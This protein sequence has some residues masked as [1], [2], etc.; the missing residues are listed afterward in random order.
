[1][2]NKFKR[3]ISDTLRSMN[4]DMVLAREQKRKELEEKYIPNKVRGVLTAE[5][6][7]WSS[8]AGVVIGFVVLLAI[9]ITI[10]WWMVHL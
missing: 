5:E 2:T 9:I 6:I 10:A 1:M 7:N 4:E 8:K 3:T